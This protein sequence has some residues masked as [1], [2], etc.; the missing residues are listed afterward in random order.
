[1]HHCRASRLRQI[2][3]LAHAAQPGAPDDLA[4]SSDGAPL[5]KEPTPDRG[6]VFQKYS[7]FSHLTVA[8]NLILASELDRAPLD[9]QV[10]RRSTQEARD[11]IEP[12]LDKIGLTAAADKFPAQLS[13]R[14]A[15]AAGDCSGPGAQAQHLAP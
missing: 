8:E 14:Y 10:V 6:I 13:G 9:G 4:R 7:V 3:L 12:L 11:D 2:H 1:M 15:T 5:P